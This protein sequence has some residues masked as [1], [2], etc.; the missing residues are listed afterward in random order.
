MKKIIL[1][2]F[3]LMTNLSFSLEIISVDPLNFG[4]V[5]EGDKTVSL[6]GIG[7]Y[8]DGKAGGIVEIIVPETYDLYGNRMTIRP[9]KKVVKLDGSGRGKFRLDVKLKLKNRQEH[10]TLTDNL[11]IKV[12]YVD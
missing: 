12:R 6:N 10:K 7:V 1:L 8:V 9:K 3:I 5:V 4:I 2:L 11:S